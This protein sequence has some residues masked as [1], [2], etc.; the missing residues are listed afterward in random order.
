[1]LA[2]NTFRLL[3]LALSGLPAVATTP[4]YVYSMTDDVASNEIEKFQRNTDG[5]LTYIASVKTGGKGTGSNPG[6]QGSL[7][8]E[9]NFLF[10]VNPGSNTITVLDTSTF[11]V[12]N[13]YP[14][15]G[16]SP[17]SLTYNNGFL[18]ALNDRGSN[19]ITGFTVNPSTGAL[20]KITTRRL[21]AGS[22]GP[23]EVSF[24]QSGTALIVTEKNTSKIDIYAVKNGVAGPPTTYASA[25]ITPYG[26]AVSSSDW[27]FVSE[28]EV[29]VG[30]MAGSVSSYSL[31]STN[32]PTAIT[33]A[34]P[35]TSTAPCWVVVNAAETYAY[36]SNNGSN[37]IS[38]LSIGPT[39][40]LTLVKAYNTGANTDPADMA[41]S[42]DGLNLYLVDAK[43]GALDAFTINGDGSLTRITG[44]SGTT[45]V[46]AGLVVQ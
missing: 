25:G 10:A 31:S 42:P 20:T 30:N 36:V 38:Q 19:N 8:L 16:T 40:E 29:G 27:F 37:T 35:L 13:S 21:S 18:Y 34:L 44:A 22:V 32:V 33:S 43:S 17:V 3:L 23:A 28:A 12:L 41:I 4:S 2:K 11:T 26:F 1:M 14:S 9:G 46:H 7:L 39:G 15:G 24:N 6:S 5:T 45:G